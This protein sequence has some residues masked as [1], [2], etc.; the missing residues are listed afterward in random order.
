M[1]CVE[2]AAQHDSAYKNAVNKIDAWLRGLPLN[3]ATLAR[4]IK[5]TCESENQYSLSAIRIIVAAV[6][7][8]AQLLNQPKVSGPRIKTV[9][10]TA[11]I[12]TCERRC[13][14]IKGLEWQ[15]VQRLCA[16]AEADGTIAG[17]RNS[18][19]IQLMSDCLL[20]VSEVVAVNVG[21]EQ[22]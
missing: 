12:T 2:H 14:Q 16:V 1:V 6:N 5:Q 7:K 19:M 17:L 4:F 10:E 3:D 22:A 20:R 18:A 21:D 9:L 11:S 15:D 13:G 8:R